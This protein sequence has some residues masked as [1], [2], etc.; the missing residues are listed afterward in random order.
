MK[1]LKLILFS[2]S[3]FLSVSLSADTTIDS[4]YGCHIPSGY[5]SQGFDVKIY[6][7]SK[8]DQA[9]LTPSFYYS[10]YTTTPLVTQTT[11]VQGVPSLNLNVLTKTRTT[12][13][14]VVF[15]PN[16]FLAEFTTYLIPPATG[17]YQFIF[18]KVDDGCMAFLGTGAFQCCDS[19]N[20]G[21][22]AANNQ[23]LYATWVYKIDGPT[24]DTANVY[25]S[26]NVAYPM[27]IVYMNQDGYGTFS[28]DIKGPS[29]KSLPLAQYLYRV[30]PSVSPSQCVTST[31]AIP[32]TTVSTICPSC[33][34]HTVTTI[35]YVTSSTTSEPQQVIIVNDPPQS[36]TTISKP[37]ETCVSPYTTTVYEY[38]TTGTTSI[39]EKIVIVSV[40]YR[41]VST[42]IPCT[43]C[44]GPATITT[45][46]VV[47]TGSS[48]E[49][50]VEVIVSTPASTIY[51]TVPCTTCTGP[52][53]ITTESVVSTGSSLETV[54]EVIVSTPLSTVY[55]TVPCPSCTGPVTITTE[56][57][58]TAGSSL[59][60]VVKVIL[61]TPVSTLTTTVPS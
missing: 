9:F 34:R 57:V 46:S 18:N 10:M 16:N 54:V 52:V 26:G 4:N 17:F 13:W 32:Q 51:T 20:V 56:S 2:L 23:I 27:R 33:T 31:I 43:D 47:S 40:P 38:I 44:T 55:T 50:V 29:G 39:P 22:D 42:T 6:K 19:N 5:L 30:P 59:E 25:L 21:V 3:F 45:E 53:T 37:C 1:L 15:A 58:V 60:T 14:G 24:G 36:T 12:Q 61:S 7:Y 41:T 35:E 8:S 48:L 28:F 11:G 49:T